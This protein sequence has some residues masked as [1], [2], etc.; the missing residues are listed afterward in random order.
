MD[1]GASAAW[2][3]EILKSQSQPIHLVE[4]AFDAADGGTIWLSDAYRPVV[5]SGNTYTANGHFMGF[6]G[7]SETYDMTI[8]SVRVSLSAVDQTWIALAL[9][10]QYIDRPLRIYKAFLDNVEAVV[11]SPVLIFDGRM[12][13]LDIADDPDG[14]TCM[15]SVT[16]SSQWAD[17]DRRPGRHTNHQEQQVF[18]PGDRGFE[19]AAQ[20]N[21]DITWGR[22]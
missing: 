3:A 2:I 10:K 20:G 9:T 12:D 5:W 1:R 22:A 18:Y 19:Y 11:T 16:A 17:F 21:K 15:L 4:V 7:L 6:S 13:T 14:G 8:P